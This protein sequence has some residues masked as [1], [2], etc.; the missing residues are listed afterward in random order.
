MG[1]CGRSPNG[2]TRG[3]LGSGPRGAVCAGGLGPCYLCSP[4]PPSLSELR[5]LPSPLPL[6]SPVRLLWSPLGLVSFYRTIHPHPCN[7]SETQE[8]SMVGWGSGMRRCRE[9]TLHLRRPS[10]WQEQA[11]KANLLFRGE[12]T[13][14]TESW[15][16]FVSLLI[17]QLIM[18]ESLCLYLYKIHEVKNS[19]GLIHNCVPSTQL[20]TAYIGDQ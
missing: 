19:L 20:D 5:N 4:Q 17:T 12:S 13:T 11:K 6:L 10:L 7:G 18:Y 8:L 15:A 16:K 3:R 1:P 2:D 9:R 14:G